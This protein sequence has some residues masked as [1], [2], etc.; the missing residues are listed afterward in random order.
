MATRGQCD[1]VWEAVLAAWYPGGVPTRGKLR[2]EIN[3]AV[4]DLRAQGATGDAITLW[5]VNCK[6][7]QKRTKDPWPLGGCTL[8]ACVENWITF[9]PDPKQ[10]IEHR[11]D[12]WKAGLPAEM[13]T[14]AG[15][16]M[17]RDAAYQCWLGAA[18][19]TF[20]DGVKRVARKEWQRLD[21]ITKHHSST[22]DPKVPLRDEVNGVLARYLP[23]GHDGD[24]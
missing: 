18:G 13:R 21:E 4:E 2:T 24:T 14:Y 12:T 22:T 20:D 10:I 15:M 8:H 23:G 7:A 5:V 17:H 3:R 16:L 9:A 11:F 6:A 1:D 19:K